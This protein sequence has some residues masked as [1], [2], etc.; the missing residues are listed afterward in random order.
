MRFFVIDDS[1]SIAQ[2]VTFLLQQAGHTVGYSTSPFLALKEVPAFRPDCILLDLIMPEIDGFELCKKFREIPGLAA[3]KIIILSAK[4]YDFDKRRARQLGADGYIVKPIHVESFT[5]EVNKILTKK[6]TLTYWG[7]HGTLPVPGPGAVRYGGNT[8]CVSLQVED[9]PLIIFDA[10]TGIKKLSNHLMASGV[11]RLTAKIFISHPHWDHI[12]ALPYF[13]PLYVQ[14]N[15][16]E[17]L[18]PSQGDSSSRTILSIQMDDVYFPVTI[19]EFGASVFFHDLREESLHVGDIQIDTLLLKHPGNCLGY[20][21]TF[22]GKTVCH[23]TDNELYPIASPHYDAVFEE[24]LVRFI[25][26]TDILIIDTTYLDEEYPAKTGWGHSCTSEVIRIATQ[27][28]VKSL[29][30]FHHDPDQDDDAIDRKLA[31]AQ[32]GL[33]RMDSPVVCRCPAEGDQ[34]V[35]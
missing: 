34:F 14:G 8:S 30:L 26:E 19:R 21:A 18:G 31:Q 9:E 25:H 23:I 20:R 24:R 15:E 12:N 28:R 10:G 7:N 2:L 17:I 11:K 1:E 5:D 16:I 4:S 35:L 6:L 13:V 3:A 32:R 29:H 22:N 27:A 33:E